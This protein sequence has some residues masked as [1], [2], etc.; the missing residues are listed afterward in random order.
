MVGGEFNGRSEEKEE[1]AGT[2]FDRMQAERMGEA[3][4]QEKEEEGEERMTETDEEADDPSWEQTVDAQGLPSGEEVDDSPPKTPASSTGAV[5]VGRGW[6]Q[7]RRR[8]RGCSALPSSMSEPAAPSPSREVLDT[9]LRQ[10]QVSTSSARTCG[11]PQSSHV[12][13]SAVVLAWRPPD[14]AIGRDLFRYEIQQASSPRSVAYT[15]AMRRQ[16]LTERTVLPGH[17]R[18]RRK[19]MHGS[20]SRIR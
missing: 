19:R 13:G 11:K 4:S 14:E 20:R 12:S 18:G 6:K 5:A 17:P 9:L 7:V 2:L 10:L 16:C 8:C 15:R 1:D 3:A